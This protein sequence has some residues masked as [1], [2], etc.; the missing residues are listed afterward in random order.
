MC[1]EDGRTEELCAVWIAHASTVPS[2]VCH[3][4]KRPHS[5]PNNTRFRRRHRCAYRTFRAVH[6][7]HRAVDAHHD[8]TSPRAGCLV[9][10]RVCLRPSRG[11]FVSSTRYETCPLTLIDARCP[12]A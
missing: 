9:H 7:R 12:Y 3:G 4:R 8:P 1:G 6:V 11:Q 10:I 2:F 5:W